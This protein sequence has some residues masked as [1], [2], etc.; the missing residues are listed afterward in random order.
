MKQQRNWIVG[1]LLFA[2][3]V[4]LYWPA[5]SFPFVDYDDYFYVCNNPD[6]SQGL[7]AHGFEYAFTTVV[8]G[9]WHPLTVLA[10]M[11]D[12]SLFG[13]NAGWHHAI[14]ILFHGINTVLLW[15]LLRRMTGLFWPSAL[16]AALFGWHPLNVE[17]VAWISELKNVL[18]T[19]FFILTLLAYLRYA[20]KPKPAAYLMALGCYALGLLAKPMLV[21]L[22]FVLLLLDYWPLK[23]IFPMPVSAKL[24]SKTEKKGEPVKSLLW[25]KVPFFALAAADS[26]VTYLIQSSSGAVV[27]LAAV[28]MTSRL[29]NVPVAYVMYLGKMIW[30]SNLC[31]LYSY[32]NGLWIAPALV[33]LMLL[34]AGTVAAWRWREKYRWLL[35]GW[36]WFLGT[37]VPVIGL[38][39]FGAQAWADRYAYLPM[40]G[41]LLI[42]GCGLNEL[43]KARAAWRPFVVTACGLFLCACLMLSWRQISYW[44]DS[45]ALFSRAVAVEP[46]SAPA[47]NLLGVAYTDVGDFDNAVAHFSVAARLH[48]ANAEFQYNLGRALMGE[49]KF[50]DAEQPLTAAVNLRPNDNTWRNTLGAAV[51]LAGNPQQAAEIFSQA[52]AQQP[53]FAMSYYNLG[54]VLLKEQEAPAAITNFLIA[55]KLQPDWPEALARLGAAYAATGDFSNAVASASQALS[56]AE[57]KHDTN[58]AGQIAAELNSFQASLPTQH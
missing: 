10:H 55:V 34:V 8:A 28:P 39:H 50:A 43:G 18:S 58:L 35:V 17:S 38:V 9:N 16:G 23:R 49:Q 1:L 24:K 47:Q 42:V 19:F 22:P 51:M 53:E 27:S 45:V 14:N 21:T 31:C 48:P 12:C 26:I 30:P 7:S 15:I 46:N 5:T 3:T 44:R 20:Q 41:L 37:L 2:V 54:I 13:Q 32:P 56:E 4:A 33:C 36:L 52:I 6:V 57:A 29:M 11:A 25:E 40:I